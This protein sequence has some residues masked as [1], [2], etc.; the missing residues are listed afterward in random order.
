MRLVPEKKVT[1]SIFPT[2]PDL[3]EVLAKPMD[4]EGDGSY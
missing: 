1:K 3:V 2:K 4:D